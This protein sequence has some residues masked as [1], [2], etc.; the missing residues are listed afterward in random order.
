MAAYNTST[1]E[2]TPEILTPPTDQ[3]GQQVENQEVLE[4][5]DD[6]LS[7]EKAKLRID[8]LIAD[9]D[10]EVRNT[11]YNRNN[12]Q[13]KIDIAAL[14]NAGKLKEHQYLIPM[15]IIDSNIKREQPAFVN[16][17]KSS[18]R[19]AIFK[20]IQKPSLVTNQIEEEF[21]RGLT[22]PG[23]EAPQ[24]K[25]VDGAQTH[26]W[27][28]VEVVFDTT[29]PLH[30]SIEHIGHDRLIFPLDSQNLQACELIIRVYCVTLAQLKNFIKK[31]GFQ[32][33]QVKTLL[34]KNSTELKKENTVE[35]H[36]CFWKIDGVVHVAWYNRNCA[37]WLKPPAKLFMGRTETIEVPP[38]P[39]GV[40][41]EGNVIFN[42]PGQE[43]IDL[44]EKLYPVFLLPYSST[45]QH[46]I[47]DQKG[48][49]FLD[50]HKQEAL[51]T[52]ISQFLNGCQLASSIFPSLKG[53]VLR[54]SELQSFK[55]KEG[56][57]PPWPVEYTSPPYP[58]AVMLN[59]QQYLDIYNS[60]EVGQ[61]NVA[62]ANRK[63]SR[64][65]AKEISVAQQESAKL[66]SVQLTLYST[67][68]RQVWNYIWPIVQ[69]QAVNNQITFL[70]SDELQ[71]N[72]VERI[73]LNYDIRSAGDIDVV[74][75]DELINQ[76]MAFWPVIQ[77][78][79][80]AMPFLA[81][82]VRLAFPDEGENYAA[83]I[84]QGD[85][86]AII[87][88]LVHILDDPTISQCLVAAASSLPAMQKG[89]LVNVLEQAK[90]IADGYMQ[91]QAA[92]NPRVRNM[93]EEQDAANQEEVDEEGKEGI[94]DNAPEQGGEQY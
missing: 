72:D 84:E 11:L 55:I 86:R 38:E 78:T 37:D 61:L 19:L 59:L 42:A 39:M 68:L 3:S 20:C 13:K 41:P 12:R 1:S 36:K 91:E 5:D 94:K 85:P 14:R 83:L 47:A 18:K 60:Q 56:V 40:D 6:F 82:L 25:V 76:Y 7:Y 9:F 65:T 81:R 16:Y 57:I 29:K 74:K 87:A 28:T 92:Q 54:Q 62:V 79:P 27:D 49:V 75:R 32:A 21:T 58:D 31:Y 45:E 73:S 10:V 8:K 71:G 23:W 44:D 66:D 89:I 88:E 53:E 17:L 70:W 2:I 43:T 22:Y 34:A 33:E 67:F 46:K 90:T 50:I 30:V 93:M 4:G 35:I 24:F 69:N 51:T 48:R 80:A 77:N 52:N 15:R 64:K 26:G 63:D